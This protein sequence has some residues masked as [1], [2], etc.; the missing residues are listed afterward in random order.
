M[1]S[2]KESWPQNKMVNLIVK[3]MVLLDQHPVTVQLGEV[4]ICELRPK[5]LV[6]VTKD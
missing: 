1:G 4:E 3:M 5:Y 6:K 2:H